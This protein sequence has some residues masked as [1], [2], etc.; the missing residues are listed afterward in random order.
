M[1]RSGLRLRKAPYG[2]HCSNT[3]FVVCSCRLY[4]EFG[5]RLC[6]RTS[7]PSGGLAITRARRSAE[8]HR[9][10]A[11]DLARR[12]EQSHADAASYATL[13]DPPPPE[14]IA[15][16]GI[17]AEPESSEDL[18]GD[19]GSPTQDLFWR[20]EDV[21]GEGDEVE[22]IVFTALYEEAVR[23]G[24]INRSPIGGEADGEEQ[25]VYNEDE[26]DY[27]TA[28]ATLTSTSSANDNNNS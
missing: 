19:E 4:N 13:P 15:P 10:I 1:L 24:F 20:Q 12:R 6:T 16:I 28:T 17:A 21:D 26:A 2:Y 18:F 25:E 11:E 5:C 3:N 8:D 22:D 14:V 27:A 23:T 9:R 7:G